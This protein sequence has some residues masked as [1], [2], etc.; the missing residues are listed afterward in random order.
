MVDG[1]QSMAG[2]WRLIAD[3]SAQRFAAYPLR[4]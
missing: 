1:C 2:G 3:Q 4:L